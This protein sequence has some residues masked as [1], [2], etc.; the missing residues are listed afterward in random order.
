MTLNTFK[1]MNQGL[2]YNFDC[3]AKRQTLN[4]KR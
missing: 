2:R 3:A 1:G 4:A